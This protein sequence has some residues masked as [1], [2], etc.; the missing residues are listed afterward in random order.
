LALIELEKQKIVS[1]N[2][3]L[4]VRINIQKSPSQNYSLEAIANGPILPENFPVTHE[5]KNTQL[6]KNEE[7]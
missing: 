5:G 6:K 3:E 1:V 7:T 2:G 4:L